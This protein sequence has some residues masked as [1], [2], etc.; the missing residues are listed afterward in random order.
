MKAEI[1]NTTKT[2]QLNM[3]L[4][5]SALI[6]LNPCTRKRISDETGLSIATCG[7]ILNEL[8][9]QNE[10]FEIDAE[11][12]S[13]GRPAKCYAFNPNHSL[14]AGIDISRENG[15]FCIRYAVANM[16]GEVI[17]E[18]HAE[19]ADVQI[20]LLE[21]TIGTLMDK[22]KLIK[23]VGIGIPGVVS[24]SA[25][26]EDCDIRELINYPLEKNLT[27]KYD[28]KVTIENDMNLKA[29]GFY[30][31]Q[32]Y[33]SLRNVAVINFPKD[34]CSGSGIIVDGHV[35]KGN[36]NFAGEVSY[37]PFGISREK[38]LDQMARQEGYLP[39]VI[40][41]LISVIVII[42]PV[43][44]A[45]TGDLVKPDMLDGIINGCRQ[46]IPEKHMPEIIIKEDINDEYIKG[47]F[48][49]TLK[50]LSCEV[51]LIRKRI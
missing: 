2:K 1:F 46:V 47:L 32:V 31:E 34:N 27:A 50:S 14:V 24:Q 3:E 21:D 13:G 35:L 19:S 4:V 37:L 40:D 16:A 29:L 36:T 9:D 28:I 12:S 23:A 39:Y 30:R 49:V 10:V 33:S 17:E 6:E 51:Q 42:N 26:V 18:N 48:Y 43:T 25:V 20:S 38:L 45:L 5:R 15:K 7:N 11:E 22:H 44:I 8:I 41:T